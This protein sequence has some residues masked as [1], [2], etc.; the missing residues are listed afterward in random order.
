MP[1]QFNKRKE[2]Q[3]GIWSISQWVGSIRGKGPRTFPEVTSEGNHHLGWALSQPRVS[4]NVCQATLFSFC[5]SECFSTTHAVICLKPHCPRAFPT[6]YRGHGPRWESL[7]VV[8]EQHPSPNKVGV[9]HFHLY[10]V[11]LPSVWTKFSGRK[12]QARSDPWK[13]TGSR[14]PLS[15]LQD[16][17]S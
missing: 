16:G 15:F 1:T 7:L 17:N 2:P 12:P 14:T 13:C 8:Q 11:L 9:T 10:D 6:S 5:D 3:K 4:P